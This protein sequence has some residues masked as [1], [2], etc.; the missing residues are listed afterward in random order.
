MSTQLLLFGT[1][2]P[3]GQV[4]VRGGTQEHVLL[5]THGQVEHS[6]EVVVH[7]SQTTEG[8]VAGV[9]GGLVAVGHHLVGPT[10]DAAEDVP[11]VL[12]DRTHLPVGLG[13]RH[14]LRTVTIGPEHPQHPVRLA[15]SRDDHVSVALRP[16]DAPDPR[17][18][19]H[20]HHGLG[21][22]AAHSP[23]V[24]YLD[25]LV[26]SAGQQEALLTLYV[27][28]VVGVSLDHAGHSGRSAVVETQ[29]SVL[30]AGDVGVFARVLDTADLVVGG[31]LDVV[32]DL[33]VEVQH[34][35]L[36]VGV[37]DHHGVLAV[38][39][40]GRDELA[41]VLDVEQLLDLLG[42]VVPDVEAASEAYAD[43]AVVLLPVHHVERE[44]VHE[45]GGV[46]HLLLHVGEYPARGLVE[47]G[48]LLLAL[49]E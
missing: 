2:P 40:D 4:L 31:G 12:H 8:V 34:L 45:F 36:A 49:V 14:Y 19:G 5:G 26:Q 33:S 39:L 13:G 9:E 15:P 16:V 20:G 22:L 27:A 3:E 38:P 44:V 37:A 21:L 30:G 28:D 32:D 23:Q 18:V 43:D 7:L 25:L 48:S 1:Q 35:Y 46:Q 29:L 24:E 42:V 10:A 11:P 41:G 6:L 17:L 47:R